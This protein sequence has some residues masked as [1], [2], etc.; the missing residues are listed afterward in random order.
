MVINSLYVILQLL[1]L[2]ECSE[3]LGGGVQVWGVEFLTEKKNS[4][5]KC[6]WGLKTQNK[7]GGGD[8]FSQLAFFITYLFQSYLGSTMFPTHVAWTVTQ[9]HGFEE[10]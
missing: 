7:F 2:G 1:G 8:F 3:G 4:T 10:V 6:S 9:Q 5:K